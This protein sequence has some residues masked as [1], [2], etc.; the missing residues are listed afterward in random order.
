[1]N[2]E[3]VGRLLTYFVQKLGLQ[4]HEDWHDGWNNQWKTMSKWYE[5]IQKPLQAVLDVGVQKKIALE[6]CNKV[7]NSIAESYCKLA[8][9][10]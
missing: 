1:M 9:P 7:L 5:E 10:Y 6:E 3:E 4:I 8:V 2:A